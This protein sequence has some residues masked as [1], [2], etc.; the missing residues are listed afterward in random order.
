MLPVTA[1][2]ETE[3]RRLREAVAPTPLFMVR[4]RATTSCSDMRAKP[5]ARKK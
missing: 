5:L 4:A 3:T 2:S 1:A